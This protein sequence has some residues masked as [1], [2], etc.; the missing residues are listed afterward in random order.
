M[1]KEKPK[2]SRGADKDIRAEYDFSGGIRGKHYKA[3]EAG[4]T[5]TIHKE[6]G[7]TVVKDVKPKL[8]TVVLSPEL[9][10]YFPN[11]ESVNRILRSLVTLIPRKGA[12]GKK[13]SS[14]RVRRM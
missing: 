3:M 12:T 2:T 5:I 13:S 1:R 14:K 10:P 9:R 7:T 4:Y 11:S 8:G 6:D